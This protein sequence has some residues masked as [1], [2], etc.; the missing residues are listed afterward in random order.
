M[1]KLTTGVRLSIIMPIFNHSDLVIE[2]MESIRQNSFADWELWAIDDGSSE[3][4]YEEIC[5]YAATDPRIHYE[6]RTAEPKGAPTCRNTGFAKAV[7]EYVCFFDSDD[8]I[9]P[10]CLERRV[11]ELAQHPELDFMVFPSTIYDREEIPVEEYHSLFGYDIYGDDIQA[12]CSR[13]LPFVVCNNIYRRQSLIDHGIEWDTS[14]RSLQDAQF[15]LSTLL[16][17]MKY[18]Y[19]HAPADYAYRISTTGSVSKKIYSQ[20]HFDSNIHAVETFYSMIQRRYGHHYDGA[21]Y[22]GAMTVNLAVARQNFS[23]EF[24]SRLARVIRHY[25][26]GYGLYFTLQI[27]LTRL[28]M[29]F[30]P[31]KV[32]RQ[33][34]MF[35]YLWRSRRHMRQWLPQKIRPLQVQSSTAP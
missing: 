8:Y 3:E 26:W 31:Y 28:L 20:E 22:D 35:P 19:C 30:L 25:S 11:E 23:R 18:A 32:A 16:A 33:I 1:D 24:T 17:G 29:I 27:L 14:L 4:H 2:M 12:F 13:T 21:L 9:T 7:G 5:R 15:N 6:R 10:Q 34:P